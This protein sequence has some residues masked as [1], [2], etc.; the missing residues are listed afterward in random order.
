MPRL[1]NALH[2]S[3]VQD[4][5]RMIA[6]FLANLANLSFGNNV[7]AAHQHD[8][9]GDSIDFLQNVT[10]NNDVHAC[11]AIASKSAIDSARAIDRGR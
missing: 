6:D 10:G 9:V 11:L 3:N 4:L 5:H 2:S 8:A 1:P 7:T